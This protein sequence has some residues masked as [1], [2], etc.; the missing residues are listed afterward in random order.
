MRRRPAWWR[1]GR[2]LSAVTDAQ[3][4]LTVFCLPYAGG[5]AHAYRPL[6]KCLPAS[7]RLVG[8]ELPGRGRRVR[9]PLCRSL[10]TLADDAFTYLRPHLPE[11]RYALFGHSMGAYLAFLCL[12]RI[13]AADLPLPAVVF[14]SGARPP[15]YPGPAKDRYLLPRAAFIDVLRTLGGCPPEVLAE[16]T[17][18]EYFE[19]ILRA[20][21]EA[22]ETWRMAVAKPLPVPLVVFHGKNDSFSPAEARGWAREST[23]TCCVHEFPGGHFF[24]QRHWP[25]IARIMV[26]ALL[27]GVTSPVE[28]LAETF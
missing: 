19:P 27:S 4:S 10:E 13:S 17:L 12:Q 28:S 14:L 16:K 11:S 21:F 26:N 9:E 25:Q 22:V 7:F 6:E 20:D 23:L 5:N 8:I 24:M 3:Q 2:K 18:I 15:A 1:R